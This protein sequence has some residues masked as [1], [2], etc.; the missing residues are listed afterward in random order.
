[1]LVMASL[2]AFMSGP[3]Q[4]YGVSV[5]VEP[6][7]DTFGW[8]RTI[9]SGLYTA[10]SLTA[11]TAM[12][13]VGRLLDRYG[14]RV[15][16][17]VVVVLFGLA[18]VWMSRVSHIVELYIGFTLLR[19]LGQGSMSLISSTMVA[20]WFVRLRGR[21]MALYAIGGAVSQAALP[22]FIYLLISVMGWMDTW[23]VLALIIWGILLLPTA[24]L[25]RRSPEAVGLLPDGDRI[26]SQNFRAQ[27]RDDDRGSSDWT[28]GDALKTKS[29]WL[30][31]FAG[32]SSSLI[33][34]AL[35][36]HHV[37]LLGSRGVDAGTAAFVLSILA[38][39]AIF[40]TFVAGFLSDR[41]P[42]R[43]ILMAGNS[44]LAIAML[45]TFTITG[46]WQAFVY[47]G[48]LGLSNGMTMT[49]NSVI[50]PN[51]YGR[52][53]LGSIKGITTTSQV[54]FA[55]LGP[56]PFGLF[57]DLTG[58]YTTVVLVF[59]ALPAFSAVAALMA[60]PPQR[61]IKANAA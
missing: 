35:I 8:S 59:L 19:T 25:V 15:L 38:P 1:M 5:F 12:L 18:A 6:M 37:S 61:S 58:N 36:F 30:L 20:L 51:Y 24:L 55:A 40:S 50:F 39:V 17:T 29:F 52:T 27:D 3:G 60:G 43:F 7:I 28:L 56:F 2:T 49:I 31:I 11:A 23:I 46:S 26:S 22:P 33:S 9:I 16:L 34:T 21:A 41:Y 32:S 14:A 47:G 44:F 48:L 54:A 13:L 57:F 42:N 53:H 45:S 10:G 4:T